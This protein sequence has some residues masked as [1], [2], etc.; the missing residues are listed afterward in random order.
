[1]IEDILLNIEKKLAFNFEETFSLYK[2]VSEFIIQDEI[3]AQKLI[4][5]ILDSKNKFDNSLNDIL[6]DLIEAVGFYPYLEKEKLKLDSTDSLIRQVYHHSDF[7]N[8][9][10]HEDQKHLLSLLK[11]DKNVIVS[12]PTS[13]GKSL[14]IEEI[15]A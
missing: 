1:M 15:I 5:N 6:T 8:K 2:I 7:L 11:T 14:L 12:A 4:V 3:L 9:Y 13:F 10:F